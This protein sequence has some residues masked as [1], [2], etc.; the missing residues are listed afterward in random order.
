MTNN[1]NDDSNTSIDNSSENTETSEDNSD[2]DPTYN[3]VDL[4]DEEEVEIEEEKYYEDDNSYENEIIEEPIG[5]FFNKDDE[6]NYNTKQKIFVILN[7]PRKQ[8]IKKIQKKKYD[9]YNKYTQI[10]K[11]YFDMLTEQ[12]KDK[13]KLLEDKINDNIIYDVPMRFRILNLNINDKTKKNI[14]NKID[15][16]N[17]MSPCSSE[18]NKLNNWLSSLNNIPFDKF[19]EIPVKISDS[20]EKI[21]EFLNNIRIKMEKTVYGH[22]DAK[23]QIIRVL[24]QLI[25]FP[26]ANGYIIGIQGSAGVGKTKLIKEGICNAL[27][28]PNAFISLGGT[29]DSSFLRGHSYTYEG[30]TYGKICE[31]LMKTGI[32][33]PLFLFDE[34]DKVSNTYKGQEIINTLIHITDPVQNDKYNDRYFEEID[35]NISRSMIIFTYNDEELI[36]PI[37]KDRMI[38]INVPGYSND[39][40]IVLAIDYII[41][42]ILKQYNLKNDEIIFN[43]DLIKHIIHN[44]PIE[45]GV[46][47]LKRAINNIISWINMMR[48]I[49]TD[50]IKITLPYKVSIDFY[51]KYCKYKNNSYDKNLHHLYI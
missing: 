4:D 26:K 34:L 44:V 10:E 42:E 51:D 36:N 31:S 43:N 15:N 14:V 21:C 46:R 38:V 27:N 24:A 28:Y 7:Q 5:G 25:S 29:D 37:L 2:K 49:P 39:E 19:Y 11:S 45:D 48:Y 22:K 32:M 8:S 3:N 41:P 47:N 50:S 17:N 23:E 6:D 35:F 40:K 30:A 16:F 18:Y 12:N 13:I 33:N 1:K 20:N 9:F